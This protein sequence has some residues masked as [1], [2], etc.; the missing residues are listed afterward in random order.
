MAQVMDIGFRPG[1]RGTADRPAAGHR[2]VTTKSDGGVKQGI[3]SSEVELIT[4]DQL[5][6]QFD[7]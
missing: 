6:I 1:Q 5:V 7:L 3:C 4:P 2:M